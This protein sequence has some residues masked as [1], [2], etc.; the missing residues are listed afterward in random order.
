MKSKIKDM[1][2]QV[3]SSIMITQM[4]MDTGSGMSGI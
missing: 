3:T 1:V 2:L 4:L